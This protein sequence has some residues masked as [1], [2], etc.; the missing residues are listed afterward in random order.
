LSTHCELELG[1]ANGKKMG[2]SLGLKQKRQKNGTRAIT[3]WC[4]ALGSPTPDAP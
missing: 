1:D 3:I 4:A 2:E